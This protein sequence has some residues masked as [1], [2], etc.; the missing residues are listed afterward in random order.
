MGDRLH[1]LSDHR[2]ATWNEGYSLGHTEATSFWSAS[3]A[4]RRSGSVSR[5]SSSPTTSR[6]VAG[7]LS[8]AIASSC[9]AESTRRPGRGFR[10]AGAWA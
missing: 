4:A 9:G 5:C 6:M 3:R 10:S 7:S 2:A 8:P 1:L